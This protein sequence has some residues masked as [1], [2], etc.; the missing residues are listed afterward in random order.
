[1]YIHI[2]IRPFDQPENS[3]L[4]RNIFSINNS[5]LIIPF[6]TQENTQ[7]KEFLPILNMSSTIMNLLRPH[8]IS[9]KPNLQS[10]CQKTGIETIP[11]ETRAQLMSKIADFAEN[12]P[13]NDTIVR[14]SLCEL[15]DEIK[16]NKLQVI[17][18]VPSVNICEQMELDQTQTQQSFTQPSIQN[19]QD[20]Q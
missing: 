2:H 12:D 18:N 8:S 4:P 17:N 7:N 20:S 10:I 15:S 14:K 1:M 16:K 13:S 19:T 6:N 9:S 3:P 5:R 11:S